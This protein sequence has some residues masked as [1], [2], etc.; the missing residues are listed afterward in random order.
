[1]KK[2]NNA[3]EDK[4][5]DKKEDDIEDVEDEEETEDDEESKDDEESDEAKVDSKDEEDSEES[6]DD[7]DSK[8]DDESD[9]KDPRATLNAQNRFLKKEG[10]V[11]K[12]GKWVKP[13]GAQKDGKKS[14]NSAKDTLS[15]FD[16]IALAKADIDEEDISY[17]QKFAKL[18]GMT[19]RQALKND[20]LKTNIANRAEKRRTS[21][22]ANAGN[23]R[24]G[25]AKLN[26]DDIVANAEAGNPGDPVELAKARMRLKKAGSKK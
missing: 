26:D 20:D 19:I 24:R 16:T 9:Q 15:T 11:F 25:N 12:D 18:E 8:D 14:D 10:Y 7:D 1:M 13:A 21:A 6:E 17:V 22:S 3:G 4:N 5:L 23:A 2:N